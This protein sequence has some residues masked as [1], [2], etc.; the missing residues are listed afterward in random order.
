MRQGVHL[1]GWCCVER[2]C[3][4]GPRAALPQTVW[5]PSLHAIATINPDCRRTRL[6]KGRHETEPFAFIQDADGNCIVNRDLVVVLKHPAGRSVLQHKLSMCTRC[7][8][9]SSSKFNEYY[10]P[11]EGQ[12]R[13]RKIYHVG[14]EALNGGYGLLYGSGARWGT[15]GEKILQPC[16]GTSFRRCKL[17]SA[18]LILTL[19]LTT[20]VQQ[21]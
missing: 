9:S 6:P 7:L 4:C 19:P 5:P 3:C 21:Y 13:G 10:V 17:S 11:Q 8:V 12:S 16:R 18:S 15:D 2:C 1:C 14:K 20:C